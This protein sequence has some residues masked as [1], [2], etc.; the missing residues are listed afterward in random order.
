[1]E[2]HINDLSLVGQYPDP[3]EFREALEPLIRL[4]HRSPTIAA[5]LYCSRSFSQRP[6]TASHLVQHA[7]L[8][9]KDRTYATLVLTWLSKAGPFW[10]DERLSNP[11][12]YFR[13]E[14][15]DVTNQGLGEAARRR[16]ASIDAG[17]FSFVYGSKRFAASP[18]HVNHG[19]EEEPLPGVDVLNWWNILDLAAAATP[20]TDSW[21]EMLETARI[22]FSR[23]KFSASINKDLESVP[24]HTGIVDLI[25]QR[26]GVLQAIAEETTDL[27][28]TLSRRGLELHQEYFVGDKA[29]FSSEKPRRVSDLSFPDPDSPSTQMFCPWHGKVK[30]GQ[31]RIHFEWPRPKN[32]REIKVGYIG[33]KITK[34]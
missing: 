28:G 25:Y 2:W 33:P 32:Q 8:A 31:F 4:R 22:R 10:D 15:T 13:F 30:M 27:G 29:Q 17:V 16:I 6:A 24:F 11:D 18:L 23:L 34:S 14:G 7:V 3:G 9:L 5:R 20:R 12:D 21:V 26:L 19:I 1:M